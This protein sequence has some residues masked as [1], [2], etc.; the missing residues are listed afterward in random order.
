MGITRVITSA[1]SVSAVRAYAWSCIADINNPWCVPRAAF[2][3]PVLFGPRHTNSRDAG[4]LIAARGGESVT[5]TATLARALRIVLTER[6]TCANAGAAAR[7][8]VQ[9]GL[10]AAARSAA[11]VE[12][13]V[14]RARL[15][16]LR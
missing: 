12:E 14:T 4:L 9:A 15:N 8:V 13:L 16:A 5:D 3:V 6:D 11:L 7:R 1:Q 10:G 2:G